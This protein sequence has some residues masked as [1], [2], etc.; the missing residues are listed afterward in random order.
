MSKF[1]VP[2]LTEGVRAKA[3]GS[4]V[5]VLATSG[6]QVW[7]RHEGEN[8]CYTYHQRHLTPIP[9]PIEDIAERVTRGHD[10]INGRDYDLALAAIRAFMESR[11]VE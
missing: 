10:D 6:T 9:E 8:D 5:T 1:D 4:L 3:S 7:V 11:G 2:E